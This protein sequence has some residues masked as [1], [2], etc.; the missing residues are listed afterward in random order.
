MAAAKVRTFHSLRKISRFSQSS[1][2][3]ESDQSFQ[4]GATVELAAT[5]GNDGAWLKD[6]LASYG[7]SQSLLSIDETVSLPSVLR[8]GTA[9]Q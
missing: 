9:I 1:D 6:T 2:D 3:P 5:I 7:V 8:A 4:A